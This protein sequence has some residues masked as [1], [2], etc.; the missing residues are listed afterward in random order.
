MMKYLC[1]WFLAL[2]IAH[3]AKAQSP[4]DAELMGSNQS[5]IA[6]FYT[7]DAWSQYWE[8]TLLRSN[9]NIGTLN[10][11]IVSAMY[12]YGISDRF[13]LLTNASYHDVSTTQGTVAGNKGLQ[14]LG[15]HMKYK[16]LELG[17][18]LKIKSFAVLGASIPLTN[19]N[20][21]AG[22]TSIGLGCGE[23]NARWT[24]EFNYN[25]GL[26]FRP[27]LAYHKRGSA[28]IE[29]SYYYDDEGGHNSSYLNVPNQSVINLTVGSR[30]IQQ[31]LRVEA[32]LLTV[33]SIGGTEIRRNE[34]PLAN[35]NMDI[36]KVALFLKFDPHFA[37]GFGIILNAEKVLSGQ[38]VGKSNAYM[39]G[40]NYR[41]GKN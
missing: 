39:V 41:F 24:T 3:Q 12:V 6:A 40:L 35:A 22:P 21:D 26:F 34:M 37:K 33:N 2:V 7:H 25:N 15:L 4:T 18:K 17:S 20:E 36:N 5:C 19:Y 29:R 31:T 8:S 30:F 13:N 38:N 32:S 10:R 14:D 9:G 16:F 23:I 11:N 28:T 27:S 1:L